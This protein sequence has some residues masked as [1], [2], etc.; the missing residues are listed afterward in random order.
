MSEL[1]SLSCNHCG[2]PL[3]AP[4]TSK[5]LTCGHCGSRLAIKSSTSAVYTEVLDMVQDIKQRNDEIADDLEE[6]RIQNELE[7][8][9][10]NWQRDFNRFASTDKYGNKQA[11]S[12]IGSV[13]AGVVM[14]VFAIFWM[15]IASDG[16][17]H[18]APAVFPLFGLIFIGAGICA[19]IFGSKNGKKYEKA[20]TRYERERASLERKLRNARD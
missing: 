15:G 11:P 12:A 14:I 1:I 13:I 2:A 16:V 20:K 6:I 17:A 19:I 3:E 8:L 10:R 4:K 5:F 18:G 7:R 9:D